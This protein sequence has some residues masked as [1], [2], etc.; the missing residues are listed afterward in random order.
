[1]PGAL[2]PTPTTAQEKRGPY[3]K[4]SCASMSLSTLRAQLLAYAAD[5]DTAT[6]FSLA[7]F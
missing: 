1:M 6:A 4:H 2:E 3:K 7:L 5:R